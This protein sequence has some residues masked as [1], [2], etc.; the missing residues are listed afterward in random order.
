[1]FVARKKK[2]AAVGGRRKWAGDE[3]DEE[4]GQGD[5]PK[6]M[7]QD[8]PDVSATAATDVTDMDQVSDDDLGAGRRANRARKPGKSTKKPLAA[9]SKPSLSFGG[10]EEEAPVQAFKINKAKSRLEVPLG[11]PSAQTASAAAPQTSTGAALASTAYTPQVLAEM[12]QKQRAAGRP[13]A[14]DPSDL[15]GDDDDGGRTSGTRIPTK[16]EIEAAR[17]IREQRRAAAVA[18]AESAPAFVPLTESTVSVRYGES[19]L[20]TEDQEIEGEEAYDDYQGDKIVFGAS[21]VVEAKAKSKKLMADDLRLAMDDDD[22]DEE[23]LGWEM[24]QI[25]KGR[26][27]D[28]E[29]AVNGMGGLRQPVPAVS[30]TIQPIPQITPIPSVPDIAAALDAAVFNLDTLCKEH[31]LHLNALRSDVE[32]ASVDIEKMS[33]E[34]VSAGQRYEYFQKLD[35]FVG[36]LDE[37]LDVKMGLLEELERDLAYHE[38]RTAA[39]TAS[40]RFAHLGSLFASFAGVGYRAVEDEAEDGAVAAP[41]RSID[42]IMTDH[43]RLFDDVDE[44]FRSLSA[45]K[46]QFQMWK[47]AYPTDY[48]NAY[49][50]LSLAAAFD[51]HVRCEMFQWRPLQAA[52]D[53]EET[54]WHRDLSTF[55][56]QEDHVDPDAPEA[57]LLAKVVEKTVVPVLVRRVHAFDPF[58]ATANAFLLRVAGSLLDYT[59]CRSPAFRSVVDAVVKQIH[60]SV[61][62][63]VVAVDV[64]RPVGGSAFGADGPKREWI[65]AHLQLLK[66]ALA[67][68]RYIDDDRLRP[69]ALLLLDHVLLTALDASLLIDTDIALYESILA[70]LP[71]VWWEQGDPYRPPAVLKALVDCFD[72]NVCG[73]VDAMTAASV[74]GGGG[75]GRNA[76]GMDNPAL[77]KRVVDVC[78]ALRLYDRASRLSKRLQAMQAMQAGPK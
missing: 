26:R 58:D 42:Q 44:Q 37:F 15:V 40:A 7:A 61:R 45:V 64:E 69:I 48:D 59:D 41:E 2:Q 18:S 12:R 47:Q 23:V 1:M 27:G 39:E 72:R 35:V 10:D 9:S 66:N 31:E 51:L 75:G 20:V 78:G 28:L 68:Q 62:R 11:I 56:Q 14:T 77:V 76:G 33:L 29:L 30:G 34:V 43:S 22:A 13:P 71:R 36:N 57:A 52:M 24:Q 46:Q 25:A 65:D 63:A 3:H 19:R 16:D 4:E 32:T 60:D 21:A 73:P 17:R 5:A 50:A 8:Q 49:G 6:P 53:L 38:K 74:G 67:W 70:V 55:G 54:E